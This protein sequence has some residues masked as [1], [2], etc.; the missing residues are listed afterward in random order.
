MASITH[1]HTV[2]HTHTHTHTHTQ[3]MAGHEIESEIGHSINMESFLMSLVTSGHETEK[4]GLPVLHI[5]AS[6]SIS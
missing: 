3:V 2:T 5:P 1:T 6:L 4:V